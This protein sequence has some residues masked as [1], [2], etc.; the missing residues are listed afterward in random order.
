MSDMTYH[1]IYYVKMDYGVTSTI[2]VQKDNQ[3]EFSK[4]QNN[5]FSCGSNLSRERS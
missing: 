4:I 3:N 5:L 1:V 2:D